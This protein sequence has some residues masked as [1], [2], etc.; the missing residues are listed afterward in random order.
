MAKSSPP[1]TPLGLF[2]SGTNE[3]LL[4]DPRLPIGHFLAGII[5]ETNVD[6]AVD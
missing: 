2:K 1:S 3:A 4:S 5:E 6:V